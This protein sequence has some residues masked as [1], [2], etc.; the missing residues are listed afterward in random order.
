[1]KFGWLSPKGEF[2][3]CSY[4]GHAELGI[5]I[6]KKFYEK[7]KYV[8]HFPSHKI[9]TYL[10]DKGWSR[11]E[12][13]IIVFRNDI[14]KSSIIEFVAKYYKNHYIEIVKEIVKSNEDFDDRKTLFHGK[15]E[16]LINHNDLSENR[17]SLRKILQ[18][19]FSK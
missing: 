16:D 12:D 11:I 8:E 19:I 14:A 4:M 17:L 7:P 3:K 13:Y 9:F 15:G 6:I 18:N 10:Y 1:M 5:E 2:H